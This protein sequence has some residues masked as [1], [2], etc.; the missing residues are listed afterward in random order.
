LV[1]ADLRFA[2]IATAAVPHDVLPAQT[3]PSLVL[4]PPHRPPSPRSIFA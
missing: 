4:R 3:A 1:V 2:P